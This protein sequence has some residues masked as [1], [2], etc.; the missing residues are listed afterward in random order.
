MLNTGRIR[1]QWHTMTRTGTSPRLSE[2]LPEPFADLHAQDAL[3]SGLREGELVRVRTRW[4]SLVARLRTSGEIARGSVFVPIHWSATNAS[5]NGA[6]M[7][8]CT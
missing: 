6:A 8:R 7:A 3:L 1:D 5:T 4:G 2:H